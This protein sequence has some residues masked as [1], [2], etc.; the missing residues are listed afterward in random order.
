MNIAK[1]SLNRQALSLEEAQAK[2][3]EVVKESFFKSKSRKRLDD[4]VNK[5]ISRALSRIYIPSLRDA[6]RRSLLAFYNNQRRIIHTISPLVLLTY[7]AL[8]RLNEPTADISKG[9]SVTEAKTTLLRELP[10]EIVQKGVARM[11]Y[12]EEYYRTKI[13]PILDNLSAQEAEDPDSQAY[14]GRRSTLRNRAEREVRHQ[15]HID[16]LNDLRAQGV[17]LVIISAHADCSD[18]CRPFQGK[19]FSLNGMSGITA[20]GREFVPIERATDIY[21]ANGKWKNGLFGFNCR[22]YAVPYADGYSF[23][24]TSLKTE[25]TEYKITERQR[26]LERNVRKWKTRAVMAQ[27]INRADYV[28]SK[29]KAKQWEAEYEAFSRKHERAY[30]RSRTKI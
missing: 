6:A 3:R 18:R 24:T 27:G 21:T 12:G 2:I 7:R 14:W 13:K 10:I 9:M 30:Y 23:P 26:A 1:D 20:D 29:N 17:T 4:D 28:Y 22:H 8:T 16:N 15:G 5:I 25:R 19:V 11:E